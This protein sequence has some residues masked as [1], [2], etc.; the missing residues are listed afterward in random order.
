MLFAEST[1]SSST[2]KYK[3]RGATLNESL[4][5]KKQKQ[6]YGDA[7]QAFNAAEDEREV[8]ERH[9]L[10]HNYCMLVTVSEQ[11]SAVES[12]TETVENSME[13]APSKPPQACK[14]LKWQ[15]Y[16]Q[17]VRLGVRSAPNSP[18]TSPK[19]P[20]GAARKV[21]NFMVMD[22]T[23]GNVKFIMPVPPPAPKPPS[24][25][26]DPLT[27]VKV[28]TKA[29][30]SIRL[31]EFEEYLA[32]LETKKKT[33]TNDSGSEATGS[34]SSASPSS[35]LT[36]SPLSQVQTI[37]SCDVLADDS[38]SPGNTSSRRTV[39]VQISPDSST[40]VIPAGESS[41]VS[42]SEKPSAK[43]QTRTTVAAPDP[44]ISNKSKSKHQL[45]TLRPIAPV[46]WNSKPAV[47]CSQPAKKLAP[48]FKLVSTGKD[49]AAAKSLVLNNV[50]GK[51]E[52]ILSSLVKQQQQVI[53]KLCNEN[54]FYI[55]YISHCSS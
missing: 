3:R 11:N 2:D 16:L 43:E 23:D 25:L 47:K 28:Q 14:I 40:N 45:A 12:Q 53:F 5:A 55:H 39:T 31:Q 29:K 9:L 49:G 21:N 6:A 46:Q 36:A 32:H 10:D 48:S 18:T 44:R 24:P 22:G 7:S 51:L 34:V 54:N 38:L 17:R 27:A 20:R 52:E 35:T 37:S 15:D 1:V 41:K 19:I 26:L 42:C 33:F 8:E 50:T 4:C 30:T 13:V